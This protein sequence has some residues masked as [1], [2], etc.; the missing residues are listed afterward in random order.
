MY[1]MIY[2][3]VCIILLIV[4]EFLYVQADCTIYTLGIG[5]P[6]YTASSVWGEFSYIPYKGHSVIVYSNYSSYP[7]FYQKL[8]TAGWKGAMG[9]KPR[10]IWA[11]VCWRIN[12]ATCSCAPSY[13]K[14]YCFPI[15]LP[16]PSPWN[17]SPQLQRLSTVIIHLT[18]HI[19]S[20]CFNLILPLASLMDILCHEPY[21]CNL[22]LHGNH[23]IR[24]KAQ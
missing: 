1:N 10:N 14:I 21:N 18:S 6:S 19:L 20:L 15:S 24:Q 3:Y 9:I 17:K 2:M 23:Q 12:S 13:A 22:F 7:L 4:M 16:P 11:R 5:T 8:I